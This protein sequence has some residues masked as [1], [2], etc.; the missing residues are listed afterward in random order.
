V[1]REYFSIIF[2][3]QKCTLY[4]IKY[5]FASFLTLSDT[6]THNLSL[7]PMTKFFGYLISITSLTL[8]LLF[9][10]IGF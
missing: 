4:S 9:C 8:F 5:S 7:F 10:E 1:C 6:N 3:V 2:N